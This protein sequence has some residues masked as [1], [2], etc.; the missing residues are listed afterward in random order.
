MVDK[1]TGSLISGVTI[2]FSDGSNPVLTDA[3]GCWSKTGLS[4][5][6]EVSADREGWFFSFQNA[7]TSSSQNV[8]GIVPV[9]TDAY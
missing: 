5:R 3:A 1:N 7:Y 9:R 6:V 4:S 2:Y 8:A